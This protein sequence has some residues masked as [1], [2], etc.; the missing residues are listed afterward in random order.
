M[1]K[2]YRVSSVPDTVSN[3]EQNSEE[4]GQQDVEQKQGK[5]RGDCTNTPKR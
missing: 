1:G 3:D 2:T 5:S 4:A